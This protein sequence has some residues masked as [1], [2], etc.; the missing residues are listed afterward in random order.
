MCRN[1]SPFLLGLDLLRLPFEGYFVHV[2]LIFLNIFFIPKTIY[3]L[4]TE[5]Y[6]Q[7]QV[8]YRTHMLQNIE[9]LN[10]EPS[11]ALPRFQILEILEQGPAPQSF[12]S[13]NVHTLR[14]LVIAQCIYLMDKSGQA[15]DGHCQVGALRAPNQGSPALS[16]S[17]SAEPER[18]I[19]QRANDQPQKQELFCV[20]SLF[21]YLLQKD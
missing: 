19:L 18:Y 6:F 5:K 11:I 13:Q 3:V 2:C 16:A 14:I 4:F 12:L 15:R 1:T 20:I 8:G 21:I 10:I 9:I 17:R 7:G